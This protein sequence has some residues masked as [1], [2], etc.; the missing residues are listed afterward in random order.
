LPCCLSLFLLESFP[1]PGLET[2]GFVSGKGR[3]FIGPDGS[4]S[5]CAGMNLGN[6]LVPKGYMFRFDTATSPDS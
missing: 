3:K 6:W 2:R 1:Q 4:R 5:S